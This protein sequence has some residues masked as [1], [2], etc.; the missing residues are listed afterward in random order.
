MPG[1]VVRECRFSLFSHNFVG[2]SVAIIKLNDIIKR[3]GI[4][5]AKPHQAVKTFL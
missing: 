3:N 1:Q 2:K 4:F 5:T